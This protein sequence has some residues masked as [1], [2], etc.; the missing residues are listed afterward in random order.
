MPYEYFDQTILPLSQ[1]IA[2][3]PN[4]MDILHHDFLGMVTGDI[5][6]ISP[7]LIDALEQALTID[8]SVNPHPPI[9]ITPDP[10][11]DIDP[12]HIDDLGNNPDVDLNI[13]HFI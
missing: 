8:L 6:F 11:L 12:Y 3:D 5:N 10:I 13:N 1:A 9:P 2:S 7:Q 4:T